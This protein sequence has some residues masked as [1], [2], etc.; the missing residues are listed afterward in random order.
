M[1]AKCNHQDYMNLNLQNEMTAETVDKI[2]NHIQFIPEPPLHDGFVEEAMVRWRRSKRALPAPV[3]PIPLLARQQMKV[4]FSQGWW[5][6]VVFGVFLFVVGYF[7][8]SVTEIVSPIFILSIVGCIPLLVV[9]AQTARNTLCGMGELARSFRIPLHRY[10]QARLLMAGGMSFLLNVSVTAMVTPVGGN[11]FMLRMTLLWSIPILINAAV[12]LIVS[13]R[14]RNF[15]HL[16]T[17]L[18][19][20]PVFWMIL[21]SGDFAEKWTMSVEVVWLMGLAVL[22]VLIFTLAMSF[23]ARVLRRGGFLIEA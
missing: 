17:V 14:L 8:L 5:R 6:E 19:M 23:Q 16:T 4:L 20:L 13:A 10:V 15:I 12:A 18:S 22:S 3:P 9:V 1:R 2:V 7:V 11:E 21:L